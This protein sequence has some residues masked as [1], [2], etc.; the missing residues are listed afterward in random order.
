[1]RAAD[2]VAV[3]KLVCYT[4]TSA[5]FK[6]LLGNSEE[7]WRFEALQKVGAQRRRGKRG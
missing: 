4:L 1:M 3:T 6:N 5:D 7:F 2:V